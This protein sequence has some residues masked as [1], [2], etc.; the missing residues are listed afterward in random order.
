M[1]ASKNAGEVPEVVEWFNIEA[2][3]SPVGMRWL[4]WSTGPCE[5]IKARSSC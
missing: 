4:K 5:V 2:G 1:S 3:E